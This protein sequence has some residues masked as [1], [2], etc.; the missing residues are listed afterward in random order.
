MP[1]LALM[2]ALEPVN[3]QALRDNEAARV[4]VWR[5]RDA[6]T[7]RKAR[8][9]RWVVARRVNPQVLAD[10]DERLKVAPPQACYAADHWT[11]ALA[12]MLSR[13][14]LPKRLWPRKVVPVWPV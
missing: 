7:W 1:L 4:E 8:L 11:T 3:A 2:G 12:T 9:L 14:P 13:L 5:A 10:M 6:R